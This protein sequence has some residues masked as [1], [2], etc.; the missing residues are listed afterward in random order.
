MEAAV[1]CLTENLQSVNEALEG[2]SISDL[3]QN[4]TAES[5][6]LPENFDRVNAALEG[7]SISDLM[8]NMA[9]TIPSLTENF[10]SVSEALEKAKKRLLLRVQIFDEKIDEQREL[11]ELIMHEVCNGRAEVEKVNYALNYLTKT[12]GEWEDKI[13]EFDKKQVELISNDLYEF[14][15]LI[16]NEHLQSSQEFRNAGRSRVLPSSSKNLYL[17]KAMEHLL[18][19]DQQPEFSKLRV[20]DEGEVVKDDYELKFFEETLSKIDD[21]ITDLK[22]N[23]TLTLTGV[24]DVVQSSEGKFAQEFKN[25]GTSPCLHPCSAAIDLL[26]DRVVEFM[27]LEKAKKN[28]SQ[29]VQNLGGTIDELEKK[30]KA[31]NDLSQSV[32]NLSL[33]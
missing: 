15:K 31:K 2:H 24:N 18:Q 20:R 13:T 11:S 23:R 12:L 33:N 28:F 9:A 30:E 5:A 27:K 32:Q 3:K 10:K 19:I 21:I 7:L 25:A 1:D 26:E 8:R 4:M 22:K 14:S 29:R 6:S 17:Q 16:R